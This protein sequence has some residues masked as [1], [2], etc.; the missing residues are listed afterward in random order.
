MCVQP[1]YLDN[2]IVSYKGEKFVMIA[3]EKAEEALK[4]SAISIKVI[5][6]GKRG[7]GFR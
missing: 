6:K 5:T 1:R 3:D 4:A 7:K 2:R